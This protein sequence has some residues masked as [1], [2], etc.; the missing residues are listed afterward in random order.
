MSPGNRSQKSEI[1]QIGQFIAQIRNGNKNNLGIIFHIFQNSI[2]YASS[3]EP[4]CR[5]GSNEESQHNVFIDK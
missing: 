1:K 5:D 3:L 2:C 4:S